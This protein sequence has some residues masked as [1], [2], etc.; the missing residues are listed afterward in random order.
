[1]ALGNRALRSSSCAVPVVAQ[2]S[3]QNVGSLRRPRCSCPGCWAVLKV[4][5]APERWGAGTSLPSPWAGRTGLVVSVPEGTQG[6]HIPTHT[7]L[8]ERRWALGC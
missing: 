8:A 2:P 1:M 6:L 3:V 7:G 4:R 5:S